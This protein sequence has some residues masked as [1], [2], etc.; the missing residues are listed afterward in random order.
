MAPKGFGAVSPQRKLESSSNCSTEESTPVSDTNEQLELA[1]NI[2]DF[3]L[4]NHALRVV[5]SAVG[6]PQSMMKKLDA[7]Y[8]SKSTSTLVS[9]M[10]EL[11]S[12]QYK[13]VGEDIEKHI[14]G[15]AELLEQLGSMDAVLSDVLAFGIL[16]A[17]IE[18]MELAPVTATIKTIAEKNIT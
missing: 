9:K 14:D 16:V 18:V 8:V 10:S 1:S 5:R 12:V 17:S 3:T 11:V 4:G 6:Q 7:Y 13:N 2:I 15:V